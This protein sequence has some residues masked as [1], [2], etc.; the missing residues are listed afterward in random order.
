MTT[1]DTSPNHYIT[2]SPH[3]SVSGKRVLLIFSVS[4][5]LVPLVSVGYVAWGQR[6]LSWVARSSWDSPPIVPMTLERSPT[7]YS[8][9]SGK[10]RKT[11]FEISNEQKFAIE[12][13][14]QVLGQPE[15]QV[16]KE[17]GAV[18]A[19]YPNFF[20]PV[21]LLGTW[22]DRVGD[23]SDA[24][25]CYE[26]AFRLAPG[27]VK[28]RFTN[29]SGQPITGLEIGTIEIAFDRVIDG[30]LNQ[31]LKLAYP[32]VVT[33]DQGLIYLP[34]FHTACRFTSRSNHSKQNTSYGTDGWFEFPG[35][36]GTLPT[37]IVEKEAATDKQR[38][39]GGRQP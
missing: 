1:D 23:P 24:H 22:H 14:K 39:S 16:R 29:E 35:R 26:Q 30:E 11:K 32:D 6:P 18:A 27:V 37:A 34:V 2:T 9:Q 36:I 4:A 31:T 3:S 33:D 28:Q 7:G 19:Q 10:W 20:Y 8:R 13:C 21:Y 17:L 5:I 12:R 38:T 15:D 25:R